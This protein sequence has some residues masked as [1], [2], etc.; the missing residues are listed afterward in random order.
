MLMLNLTTRNTIGFKYW[1]VRF[2]CQCCFFLLV[3]VTV[4]M[5]AYNHALQSSEAIYIAIISY[6]AVFLYLEFIQCF[7]GWARYFKYVMVS[8]LPSS[9][10]HIIKMMCLLITTFYE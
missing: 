2:L 10:L 6:S 4:L 3:L 9:A 5:Q 8:T 7:R 1:L